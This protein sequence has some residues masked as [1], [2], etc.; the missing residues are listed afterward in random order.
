MENYIKQKKKKKEGSLKI[1]KGRS[2]HLPDN[3]PRTAESQRN[4]QRVTEE[5]SHKYHLQPQNR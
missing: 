3:E 1:Q 2:G 4:M 5:R